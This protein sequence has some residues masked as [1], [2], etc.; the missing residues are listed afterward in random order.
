MSFRCITCAVEKPIAEFW[1]QRSSRT[2]HQSECKLCMGAR[3]RAWVEANRQ[4]YRSSNLKATHA[5]RKR[6]PL[7]RLYA[8]TR[9]RAKKQDIPFTIEMSDIVLPISCPV[10]GITLVPTL[11]NGKGSGLSKETAPSVD[12]IDND[13]GYIP[14]NVVV[15]SWR[16]N[17]IKSDATPAELERI[18]QFYGR[19]ESN[20]SGQT[21]VPSV[22]PHS[23]EEA[24]PVF[25]GVGE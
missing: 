20:Q 2:G 15:V 18:A 10:L 12:R 21:N 11:G 25:V 7:A 17:R 1:R 9:N 3:N 19:L 14:G 13:K 8:Y 16:A 22:Q 24:R 6:D 4:R 23:Q 5:Y